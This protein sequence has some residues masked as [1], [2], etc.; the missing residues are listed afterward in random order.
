MSAI[1]GQVASFTRNKRLGYPI[2]T[3][4]TGS[5]KNKKHGGFTSFP[6]FVSV[7]YDVPPSPGITS[8]GNGDG[9]PV[10]GASNV[11]DREVDDMDD[12]IPF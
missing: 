9:A 10:I 5:Y 6:V 8:G 7:G 11:R 4:S 12:D 3:L 1:A 2:V